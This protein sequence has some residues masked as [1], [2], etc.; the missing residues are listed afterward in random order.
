[1]KLIQNLLLALVALMLSFL[2]I[3]LGII[4]A[5]IFCV[6]KLDDEIALKYFERLF[7]YIA[8]SIDKV[9]NFA[10]AILFNTCLI[11]NS[12]RKYRFGKENQ[13]ISFVMGKNLEADNLTFVGKILNDI[14]NLFEKDHVVK[15]VKK[16]DDKMLY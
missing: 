8:L 1:M 15:T 14:L 2:L 11:K 4:F 16:E 12:D 7:L 6:F 3:P 10:C 13:T 9:G 5:I